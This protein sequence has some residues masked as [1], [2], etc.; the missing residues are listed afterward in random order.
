MDREV[1]EVDNFVDRPAG[2]LVEVSRL[3]VPETMVDIEAA[4]RLRAG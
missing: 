2:T 3:V 4:A 1:I